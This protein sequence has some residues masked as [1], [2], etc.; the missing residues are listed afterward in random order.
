MLRRSAFH[1]SPAAQRGVTAIELMVVVA[2]VA[3]LAALAAPSF[4]PII[5]SWRVRSSSDAFQSA[6]FLARAEAIKRGGDV[7]LERK[8][9]GDNCTST[10][11][12]DWTCG[13]VLFHD[14]NFDGDRAACSTPTAPECPIQDVTSSRA[15]DVV[16][17]ISQSTSGKLIFNRAGAIVADRNSPVSINQLQMDVYA[18]GRDIAYA[19]SKKICVA[20]SGSVKRIPGSESC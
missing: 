2:I 8:A 7:I 6:I 11:V 13:W 12:N 9:S 18:K 4:T 20:G 1:A 5:E 15:Q 14:T 3:I 19:N 10:G 17:T 16:L